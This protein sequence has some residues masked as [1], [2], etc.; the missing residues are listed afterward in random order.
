MSL[1][2]SRGIASRNMAFDFDFGIDLSRRRTAIIVLQGI[3]II[4]VFSV[5]ILETSSHTLADH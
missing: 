3:V 2:P 5:L 4:P 1:L